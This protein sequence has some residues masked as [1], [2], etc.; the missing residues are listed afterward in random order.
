[1]K[2]S[3]SLFGLLFTAAAALAQPFN[4]TLQVDMKNEDPATLANGVSVAGSFQSKI[5]GGGTNWTPGATMMTEMPAGSKKYSVTVALT[6]ADTFDFKFVK[7]TAWGSNEGISGPCAAPGSDNRR[8]IMTGNAVYPLNCYNTCEA[9][10]ATVDTLNVRFQVDL[11]NMAALFAAPFNDTV[12]VA[13]SFAENIVNGVFPNWRPAAI[14]MTPIAPGSQI[15]QTALFR[16]K[17]GSYAYK[18]I[19]GDDWPYSENFTG[20]CVSGGNRTLT[21]AGANNS[22]V[23]V[24]PFC[25]N[26]CDAACAALGAPRPVKFTVDASDEADGPV[27]SIG[28]TMQLKTFAGN[29]LNM[30]DNNNGTFSYTFSAMYPLTYQYRYFQNDGVATTDEN[31]S[32]VNC[33]NALAGPVGDTRRSVTIPAGT[34]LYEVAPFY[35]YNTCTVS[36]LSPVSVESKKSAAYF[37]T[38]PNPFTGS[39]TISFSNVENQKF[40]VVVTDIAGRV[41]QSQHNLVGNTATIQGLN[42]GVFFATLTTENGARYTQKLIAE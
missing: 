17:S 2:K 14:G 26:S 32:P 40:S 7:G 19:Y 21:L 27:Y 3:L 34:G 9:C 36:P 35:K 6:E 29:V 23:T 18:F 1:M 24:V 38:A 22:N 8:V 41:L 39:T 25:F 28:G 33:P 16:I 30:T 13:G 12:S 10:P 37:V 20:A 31:F 5:V 15:Y 42:A 11:T 4:L